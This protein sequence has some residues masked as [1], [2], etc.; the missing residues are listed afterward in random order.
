[1]GIAGLWSVWKSPQ[2]A[3]VFSYTMLTVNADAHPLMNQFHKPTDEKRMVVILPPGRYQDWLEAPVKR[4]I[5][6]MQKLAWGWAVGCGGQEH[7]IRW[8]SRRTAILNQDSGGRRNSQTV[9]Q[10]IANPASPVLPASPKPDEL[11]VARFFTNFGRDR[12]NLGCLG[13]GVLSVCP[14][15]PGNSHRFSS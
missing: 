1:M 2:G 15:Q 14:L 12:A 13:V 9:M 5:A 3:P 7:Y 10:C 8:R 4:S 11:G 6:F